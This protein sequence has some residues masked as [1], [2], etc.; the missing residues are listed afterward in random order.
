[1]P[2]HF[3]NGEKCNGSKIWARV[4]AML[5]QFQNCMK[6]DSKKLVDAKET[7]MPKNVPPP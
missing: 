1:M 7:L 3:E 5:E 2:A 4:H 6:F